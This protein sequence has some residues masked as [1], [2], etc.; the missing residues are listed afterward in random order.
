MTNCQIVFLMIRGLIYQIQ[1]DTKNYR[2]MANL[3]TGVTYIYLTLPISRASII[4]ALYDIKA[5]RINLEVEF[6]FLLLNLYLK[7]NATQH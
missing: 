7:H 1:I 4:Y 5:W 3:L 2:I 6:G